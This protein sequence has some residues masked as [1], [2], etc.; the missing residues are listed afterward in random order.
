[1]NEWKEE[2]EKADSCVI[3]DDALSL[4]LWVWCATSLTLWTSSLHPCIDDRVLLFISSPPH[5]ILATSEVS[6]RTISSISHY[7]NIASTK[8]GK[9]VIDE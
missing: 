1:L 8:E 3:L 2:I 9:E 6:D 5:Q 4:V 7:L